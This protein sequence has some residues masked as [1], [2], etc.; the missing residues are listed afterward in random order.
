MHLTVSSGARHQKSFNDHETDSLKSESVHSSFT[1]FYL[2]LIIV[3]LFYLIKL[4]N[5]FFLMK[6]KEAF[7]DNFAK[8]I[9][10]ELTR[11]LA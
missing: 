4:I 1:V 8:I 11:G 7:V 3:K 10:T 2:S 9:W 6:K 5:L